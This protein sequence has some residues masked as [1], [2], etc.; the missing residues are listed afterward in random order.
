[1][2]SCS[3]LLFQFTQPSQSQLKLQISTHNA[4]QQYAHV[5]YHQ[6]MNICAPYWNRI[7]ASTH[8][9]QLR[10]LAREPQIPFP[11]H[12]SNVIIHTRQ[13]IHWWLQT[14]LGSPLKHNV[15]LSWQ[16]LVSKHNSKKISSNNP[17]TQNYIFS[18]TPILHPKLH[19]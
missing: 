11:P 2:S 14:Q 13:I 1:M 6:K 12:C 17:N 16:Y 9:P 5:P 18:I 19:N 3:P 10:S 7:W 8:S 15:C 4:L